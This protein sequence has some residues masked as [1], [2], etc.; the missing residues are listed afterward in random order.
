MISEHKLCCEV[1]DDG[2]GDCA[3]PMYGLAPHKHNLQKTGGTII[4]STE[5]EPKESWPDNF[6]EDPESPGC[7]IYAECP[8][9]G[10][11]NREDLWEADW[12]ERQKSKR[13]ENA[14]TETTND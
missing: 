14:I 2:T 1:C 12:Q 3:Y 7:G 8:G 5:I 9:C 10:R 11:P 13:L 6:I 4:G